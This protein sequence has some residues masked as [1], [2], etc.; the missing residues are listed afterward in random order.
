MV[1]ETIIEAEI[2]RLQNASVA[3]ELARLGQQQPALLHYL[4]D[5]DVGEFSEEEQALLFYGA[6]VL[7]GALEQAYGP[8][9]EIDGETIG[10]AEDENFALLLNLQPGSFQE[11]VT[12]FFEHSEEED[13]LAFIED[14][15]SATG[16]ADE[17]AEL[18]QAGLEPL[19]VHPVAREPLFA[20]LKTVVDVLTAAPQ[21]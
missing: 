2:S 7:F 11:R 21:K 18:A 6:V 15:L 1:S 14:L 13:L 9:E 20:I 8:V 5:S 3:E 16:E 12:V 17:V 4:N 10:A 19:E